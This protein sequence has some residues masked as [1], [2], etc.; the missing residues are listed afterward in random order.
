MLDS[1]VE[2]ESVSNNKR[3]RI[4]ELLS[5]LQFNNKSITREKNQSSI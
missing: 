3:I 5:S 1:I 4:K 2:V